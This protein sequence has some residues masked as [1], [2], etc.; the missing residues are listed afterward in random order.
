MFVK[1]QRSVVTINSDIKSHQKTPTKTVGYFVISS[2][3]IWIFC[4]WQLSTCG[5]VKFT[6]T[7]TF[8]VLSMLSEHQFESS[9]TTIL[10]P[11]LR[12]S[13]YFLQ[14]IPN[15]KAGL[16]THQRSPL[17][18]TM[19]FLLEFFSFFPLFLFCLLKVLICFNLLSVPNRLTA[20]K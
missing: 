18:G 3:R 5:T 15:T 16:R 19:L 4:T 8:L 6:S 14:S 9:L 13:A 11:S 20:F 12:L 1:K 2:G 17:K 7:L 10:F